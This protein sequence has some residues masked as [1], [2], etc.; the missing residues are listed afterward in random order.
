MAVA[1]G[2]WDTVFNAGDAADSYYRV[3]TGAVRQCK[4]LSD[5]RRHIVDFFLPGDVFGY[6]LRPA[7]DVT[8]EAIAD[9]TAI[10]FPLGSVSRFIE[11]EPAAARGLLA[12]LSAWIASAQD[13]LLLLGR[14]SALERIASFLLMMGRRV[15][16]QV[17]AA[18]VVDLPMTRTDIADHLG[19]TAETVCRSFSELRARGL[20]EVED[21]TW[22]RITRPSALEALSAGG[23]A[24]ALGMAKA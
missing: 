15:G 23:G 18:I 4:L 11:S 14:K 22:I 24:P 21:A 13:Q 3:S 7:Y 5:G 2:K 16:H 10:R 1:F 12:S 20:I 8:A 19:L 17:G 9:T 6:T